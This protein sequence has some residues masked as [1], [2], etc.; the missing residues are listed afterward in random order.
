[1]VRDPSAS[2]GREDPTRR[3]TH[4]LG[5]PRSGS[6]WWIASPDSMDASHVD[7]SSS[8]VD[9][10]SSRVDASSS[11][12][13]VMEPLGSVRAR[14]SSAW[15]LGSARPRSGLLAPWGRSACLWEGSACLGSAC[16]GS[17]SL[18]SACL[19]SA[20]L[21]CWGVC[22]TPPVDVMARSDVPS[23]EGDDCC[24]CF[25]WQPAAPP[26]RSLTDPRALDPAAPADD[27]TNGLGLGWL[28]SETDAALILPD[29]E[30]RSSLAKGGGS[31]D[32]KGAMGGDA[33]ADG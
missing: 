21:A 12:D 11:M 26:M 22:R 5:D 10:S 29:P 28:R 15:D 6:S 16:L 2:H 3:L 33:K 30:R 20:R 27:R 18:G 23:A 32:D 8:R 31:G 14:G 13:P 4:E 7:P 1:M 17:P 19:G 24:E 25:R 9:P